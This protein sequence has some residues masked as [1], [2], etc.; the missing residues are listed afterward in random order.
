MAQQPPITLTDTPVDLATVYTT[1][2]RYL[3][4]AR[5]F[6]D[7]RGVLYATAATAPATDGGY[8]HAVG[9]SYFTFV[10]DGVTKTWAKSAITGLSVD[11]A[12][13]RYAD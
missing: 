4:Q 8:Y 13:N 1:P 11:M 7:A 6:V 5:S 10:I 12:V 3:A 2:G 9:E